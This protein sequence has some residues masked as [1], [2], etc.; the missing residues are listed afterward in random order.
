MIIKF[1]KRGREK[2]IGGGQHLVLS[3]ADDLNA[4]RIDAR[5]RLAHRI[6]ELADLHLGGD[7]AEWLRRWTHS[8]GDLVLARSTGMYTGDNG[9]VV[10]QKLRRIVAELR[11][12]IDD[13]VECQ[14]ILGSGVTGIDA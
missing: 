14:M 9:R 1:G 12:L 7:D 8:T 11:P 10:Q 3:A 6:L 5:K 13:D 2:H 4:A